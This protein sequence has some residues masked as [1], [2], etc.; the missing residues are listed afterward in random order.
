MHSC[1]IRNGT[2]NRRQTRVP[3]KAGRWILSITPERLP[4]NP[5]F[6]EEYTPFLPGKPLTV[7]GRKGTPFEGTMQ[8]SP[9]GRKIERAL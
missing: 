7:I 5:R 1:S 8:N 4:Y 2:G 9:R 6:C 3:D